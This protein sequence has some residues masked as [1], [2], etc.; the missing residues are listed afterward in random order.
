MKKKKTKPT[1]KIN[2]RAKKNKH[3]ANMLIKGKHGIGKTVTV[4]VLLESLGYEIHKLNLLNILDKVS[5]K[6]SNDGD[7]VSVHQK[8]LEKYQHFVS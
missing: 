2:P 6:D 5:K 7:S 4:T 8:K 1:A 3:Y